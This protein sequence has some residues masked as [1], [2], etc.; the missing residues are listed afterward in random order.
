MLRQANRW[1]LCILLCLWTTGSASASEAE[2][3][4]FLQAYLDAFNGKNVDTL[5]EMWGENAVH[6]DARSDE[7]TVGR[8]AILADIEAVFGEAAETTLKGSVDGVHS[9]TDNVVTVRGTLET[10]VDSQV[11]AESRYVATLRKQAGK[12]QFSSVEEYDA[13]AIASAVNGLA[14]LEWLVGDWVDSSDEA[15]VVSSIKYSANNAFLVRIVAEG[16]SNSEEDAVAS[17]TITQ[18][19]GWDPRSQA[20]RSWSFHSDGSF[21]EGVWTKQDNRWS[22]VATQ[23]LPNGDLATGTY[24]MTLADEQTLEIQLVGHE[25]AGVPMP[26]AVPVIVTRQPVA[27]TEN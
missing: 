8:E 25:V 14:D 12:W 15:P 24:V 3:K 6:F 23:T 5:K 2:V 7:R 9:V 4:Q 11:V 1:L 27:A 20:I 22:I 26:A 21:G 18:I 16:A 19:I 13:P 17:R 10:A